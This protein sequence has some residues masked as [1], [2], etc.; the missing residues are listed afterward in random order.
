MQKKAPRHPM[1]WPRKLPTGAA[2]VVA[3]AF[4]PFRTPSARATSSCGTKRMTVA[5]DID[6]KPPMTTPRSARPAIKATVLGANA[7]IRPD[8]II[9]R[10]RSNRTILRSIPRV[11]EEIVRLVS[12]ANRPDTAIA[13]PACPSVVC[14]PEA[15]GVSRLTGMNSDAISVP[16]HS[17]R[18]KTA[19]HA[20]TREEGMSA[21][22]ATCT[23][24][25]ASY[26][27]RTSGPHRSLRFDRTS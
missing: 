17:V 9:R 2:M 7:T 13:W 10:V 25:M 18:A 26:P 23:L 3:R 27:L 8:S 22:V 24:I 4:P 19:F 20:G 11:A 1:Y 6:Q 21:C 12:T 16:T 5:A 14:R 15:I